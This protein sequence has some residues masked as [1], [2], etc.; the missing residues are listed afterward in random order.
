MSIHPTHS[1]QNGAD[2]PKY[3]AGCATFCT[4]AES[5]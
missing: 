3:F 4:F 2:Y 1:S 5:N